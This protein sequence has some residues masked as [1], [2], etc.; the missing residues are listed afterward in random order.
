MCPT[1]EKS[2]VS[3]PNLSMKNVQLCSNVL[4]KRNQC[5]VGLF[6]TWPMWS[7]N[8]T[9]ST[10]GTR[11]PPYLPGHWRLSLL[12]AFNKDGSGQCS[13]QPRIAQSRSA[14]FGECTYI[15]FC[16][17]HPVIL[18]FGTFPEMVICTVLVV[19]IFFRFD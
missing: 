13:G 6:P 3:D 1:E 2:S 10:Q 8:L 18:S 17:S 9:F 19:V 14:D 15:L 11:P 4:C 12:V 5:V 16:I 7:R